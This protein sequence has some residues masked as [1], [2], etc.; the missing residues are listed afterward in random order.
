MKGYEYFRKAMYTVQYMCYMDCK[1]M[2][3]FNLLKKII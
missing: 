1:V 2:V 3:K